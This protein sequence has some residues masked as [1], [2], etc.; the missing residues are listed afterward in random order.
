M[1]FCSFRL[2][3]RVNRWVSMVFHCSKLVFRD[4]RWVC[5][6]FHG[7]RLVFCDHRWIFIGFHGF[8]LVFRDDGNTA[9]ERQPVHKREPMLHVVRARGGGLDASD[10][11]LGKITFI[12]LFLLLFLGKG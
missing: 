7:S 5:M 10:I 9:G 3:S 2:V 1:S 12:L 8:K 11:R 6:I 4:F